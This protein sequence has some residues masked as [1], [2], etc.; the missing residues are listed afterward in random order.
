MKRD[1]DLVRLILLEIEK[2]TESEIEDLIV[3]NYSKEEIMFNCNLLFE[4]NLIKN[5]EQDVLGYYKVGDLTWKGSDF[6]DKIR[7]DSIW[8]KIKEYIKKNGMEITFETIKR[9][10]TLLISGGAL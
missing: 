7:D 5:Y 2:S 3:P 6:L 9:V 8:A 10:A 4:E 1:M